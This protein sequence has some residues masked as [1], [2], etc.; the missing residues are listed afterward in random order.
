MNPLF[1]GVGIFSFGLACIVLVKLLLRRNYQPCFTV[2]IQEILAFIQSQHGR[3]DPAYIAGLVKDLTEEKLHR[4]NERQTLYGYVLLSLF[5]VISISLLL[6]A[7]VISAEAGLPILSGVIGI[8][9]GKGVA[10]GRSSINVR[11][12]E[13]P[14]Q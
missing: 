13:R 1:A 9:I 11:D 12:L 3:Y 8:A 6:L 14:M 5:V 2:C 7:R 4:E 10:P